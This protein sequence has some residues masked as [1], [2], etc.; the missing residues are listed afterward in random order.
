MGWSYV[1][2]EHILLALFKIGD[3]LGQEML[4][5]SGADEDKARQALTDWNNPKSGLE[6][7]KS[8]IRE[9]AGELEETA[10]LPELTEAEKRTWRAVKN[11]LL[12]L[13]K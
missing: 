2:T 13:A 5:A 4:K 8:D 11:K 3:G 1:G 7:L 12:A 9:I 10:K 6:K